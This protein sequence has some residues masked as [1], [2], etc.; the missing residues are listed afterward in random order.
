MQPMRWTGSD[1]T[2]LEA[3]EVDLIAA[4][5]AEE[6]LDEQYDGYTA[7]NPV[8]AAMVAFHLCGLTVSEQWLVYTE[9]H[10]DED[11]RL[12]RVLVER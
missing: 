10:L 1:R 11:G 2:L 7:R 12:Y 4:E 3:G 5:A 6:I 8:L 9:E